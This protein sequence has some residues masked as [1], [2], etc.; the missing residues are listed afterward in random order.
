MIVLLGLIACSGSG[1]QDASC[2]VVAPTV[3]G[4]VR[5]AREAC[6]SA[7]ARFKQLFSNRAPR[8]VIVLVDGGSQTRT[9]GTSAQWRLEWPTSTVLRRIGES[10]GHSGAELDA[11]VAEQWRVTL[12]HEIGHQ[13]VAAHFYPKGFQPS[14]YGTPLPDWFDEAVAVWTEPAQAREHRWKLL[15]TAASQLPSLSQLLTAQLAAE[16]EP[17]AVPAGVSSRTVFT[18]TIGPCEGTCPGRAHPQ[19]TLRVSYYRDEHGNIRA[20]T[21]ALVPQEPQSSEPT[22][23]YAQALAL[24]EYIVEH[25]GHAAL[26]ELTRRL[27]EGEDGVRV[28]VGLPG[29]PPT[30]QE[31]ERQWRN[32]VQ[33]RPSV[34]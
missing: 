27:H 34:P 28:I 32:W 5:S 2:E 23:F 8:G 6:A 15:E 25:G 19:E 18:V 31:T 33:R 9:K 13:M 10:L 17:V 4:D 1:A 22:L 11:F 26:W 3:S 30:L 12:P 21:A 16:G 20:D 29:L 7:Q 14:G 24:L